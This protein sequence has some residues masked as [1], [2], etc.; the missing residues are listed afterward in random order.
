[1]SRMN[2][3][4]LCEPLRRKVHRQKSHDVTAMTG[5]NEPYEPFL[6]M[7]WEITKR[8]IVSLNG[9]VSPRPKSCSRKV[10]K[11]HQVKLSARSLAVLGYVPTSPEVHTGFIGFTPMIG[12]LAPHREATRPVAV[13]CSVHALVFKSDMTGQTS[14]QPP[15]PS[16]S[17]RC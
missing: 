14:R 2:P 5:E 11:V 7:V 1:M 16:H 3:M 8:G 6:E 10:Q 12:G 15:I 9:R 17:Y 13:T 4:N